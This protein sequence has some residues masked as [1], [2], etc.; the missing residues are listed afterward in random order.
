MRNTATRRAMIK[1]GTPP[2]ATPN[3]YCFVNCAVLD[4][5]ETGSAAA[6]ESAGQIVIRFVS[7]LIG[8]TVEDFEVALSPERYC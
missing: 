4:S 1:Q 2:T 5:L 8:A 6:D 7:K 3:V